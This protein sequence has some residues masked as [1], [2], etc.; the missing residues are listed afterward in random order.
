MRLLRV[1]S[2][3]AGILGLKGCY[4]LPQQRVLFLQSGDDQLESTDLLP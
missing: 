4:L 1:I 2:S 3:Q